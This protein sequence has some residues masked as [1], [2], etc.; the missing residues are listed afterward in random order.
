MLKNKYIE[1]IINKV[2]DN[3]QRLILPELDDIRISKAKQKMEDMGFNILDL[4]DY[5]DYSLYINHI[6]YV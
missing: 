3:P 2:L 6:K 4:N 1:K 5:N